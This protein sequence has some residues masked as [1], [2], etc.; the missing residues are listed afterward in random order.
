MKA[1]LNYSVKSV[2]T[3]AAKVIK[4]REM[5]K[6]CLKY[7]ILTQKNAYGYLKCRHVEIERA[8]F[9]VGTAETH[10]CAYTF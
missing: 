3:P 4:A 6:K 9:S 2:L 7:I 10:T 1:P 8:V 5:Y